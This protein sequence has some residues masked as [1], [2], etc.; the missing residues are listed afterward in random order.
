MGSYGI[1]PGRVM[2]AIVEQNYDEG[3]IAAWPPAVG[4]YEAHVVV[5]PGVEEIGNRVAAAL[6]AEGLSVLL[7]DRDQRAGEK[8]ADADL[9][10]CPVR[11]T[12][13]KKTLEDGAADVLLRRGRSEE[14]T[15]IGKLAPRV[16]EL[17]SHGS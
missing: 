13:G 5:L 11:V 15:E 9:I 4:P 8:F 3:G 10:G 6:E 7:D 1:G 2:A 12:V 17:L 14:R 16:K